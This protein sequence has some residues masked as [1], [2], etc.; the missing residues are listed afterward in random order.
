MFIKIGNLREDNRANTLKIKESNNT[1]FDLSSKKLRLEKY[2]KD[3]ESERSRL[4]K[5]QSEFSKQQDQLKNEIKNQNE[6]IRITEGFSNE[7]KRTILNL[8]P[9]LNDLKRIKEQIKQEI[10]ILQ[11]NQSNEFN[12][13]LEAQNQIDELEE[14]LK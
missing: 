14:N 8:E 10:Q 1:A 3:I 7:N 11:K 6:S 9:N 4:A 2:L 12:K 13:G 5:Q